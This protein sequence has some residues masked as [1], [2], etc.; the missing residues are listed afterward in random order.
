MPV[1]VV[2]VLSAIL[3]IASYI[4]LYFSPKN[5]FFEGVLIAAIVVFALAF[6]RFLIGAVIAAARSR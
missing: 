1:G 5:N 3:G 6:V 2:M 4:G